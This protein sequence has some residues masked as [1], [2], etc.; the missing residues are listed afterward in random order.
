M[1]LSIIIPVLNEAATLSQTLDALQDRAADPETIVVD[2]GSTDRSVE[3]ARK[4]TPHVFSS[5][6]G[7]GTQQDAGARRAQGDVFVFL[8]ADTCLPA[9]YAR[10]IRQALVDPHVVFGAFL[11]TINPSTPFLN[12]IALAANLRSILFRL[13]Y[14][15]QALFV[16][17]SAYFRTGGFAPWPIM[18]DVDLVR[19]L[20][21]IG[22]AKLIRKPV[23]TAARRWEKERP[24]FATFRNWW[25][26]IRYLLG[27]SPE[28]LMRHYPD[29]R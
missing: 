27:A 20:N 22:G 1:R 6:R 2:G 7:R 18:E 12:G 25:L 23:K 21:R 11:L 3:I 26:M 28:A 10:H 19:R 9:G 5:A 8:H 13:P 24:V 14:G 29:T 17:R 15:D 16:R 4:Y